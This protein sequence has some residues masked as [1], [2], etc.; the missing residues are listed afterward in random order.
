M[1]SIGRFLAIALFFIGSA[2]IR[3]NARTHPHQ[4]PEPPTQ[5]S[6]TAPP[7][8]HYSREYPFALP[9]NGPAS[10]TR[11]D[12]NSGNTYFMSRDALGNVTVDGFNARTGSMWHGVYGPDGYASGTDAEMNVWSYDPGTSV[13]LNS[14]G[15]A[16]VG[17]G[18]LQSCTGGH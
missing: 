18:E 9:G 4:R 15:T 17:T 14:N 5:A 8:V 7:S 12:P 10:W 13:Y 3:E 16:C 2:V 11:T 1:E 6:Y